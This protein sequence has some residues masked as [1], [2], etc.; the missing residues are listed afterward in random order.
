MK[1]MYACSA[2]VHVQS[3]PTRVALNL[4]QVAVTTDEDIWPGFIQKA[5]NSFCVPTGSSAN[6][7][8]AKLQPLNLPMQGFSGF[9]THAVVIDV[10]EYHPNMGVQL[11]H[12]VQNSEISNIAGMP[13]FIAI[14]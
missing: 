9:R 5:A 2:R 3:V 8:H 11:L 13:Y 4:Q 12:G 10:A 1:T 6:V 7:G 14:G